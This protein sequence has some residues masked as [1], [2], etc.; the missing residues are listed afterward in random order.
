[1]N[2]SVKSELTNLNKPAFS[3]EE[4]DKQNRVVVDK[5]SVSVLIVTTES[6]KSNML[7]S[8]MCGSD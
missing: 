5:I 8:R 2:Q 1:M 7:S 6:T 3:T 4:V